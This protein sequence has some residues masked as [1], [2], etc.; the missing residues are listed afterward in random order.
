MLGQEYVS[1]IE[2]GWKHVFADIRTH[3]RAMEHA[4][5]WPCAMGRR[6]LSQSICILGRSDQDWSADYKVFSRSPWEPNR[7]FDPVVSDYLVRYPK[8][9]VVLAIDDTKLHKTGKRIPGAS[10]QRDPM[11]P[12][13]QCNFIWGL[14]F[15]QASLIFPHHQEGEFSARSFPVRFDHVPVVKK[16]GKRA[17]EQERKQNDALRKLQNLSASALTL[18]REFRKELNDRGVSDRSLLITADGSFCNRTLFRTPIENVELLVRCRK[19]ARLCFQDQSSSR[20]RYAVEKF[21]PEDVR[22]SDH[23]HWK[24]AWI[25]FGTKRRKLRYKVVPHVLWQ[26]GAETRLLRLI[27]LAPIPYKMSA[28]SRTDYRDPAFLLT[29][30][31]RTSVQKLVQHYVDRWQI[32]VNHRDEKHLLSVGSSQVRSQLSVPRHPTFTVASYSLLLLADLRCFGPGRTADFLTLPKW[33]NRPPSRASLQ[34]LLTRLRL[35]LSETS[36]YPRLH[37]DFAKNLS[38]YPKT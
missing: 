23:C 27:I 24:C 5:A 7:L 22:T 36:V 10:W 28:H 19:D 26:R 2:D 18:V 8:Q 31:L 15:L 13:F 6:T 11:S 37:S 34:D 1:L 29:T 33:R 3:Q 16:A 12:P 20:R 14:R 30:D 21:T 35:D 25:H 32:E 38:T 17:T 4:V 9:P